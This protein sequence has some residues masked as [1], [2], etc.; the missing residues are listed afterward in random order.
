MYRLNKNHVLKL[1]RVHSLY[2]WSSARRP[3]SRVFSSPSV[4][5]SKKEKAKVGSSQ[6]KSNGGYNPKRRLSPQDNKDLDFEIRYSSIRDRQK[7]SDDAY[8]NLETEI[9]ALYRE[10]QA[11][12]INPQRTVQDYGDLTIIGSFLDVHSG[13]RVILH[14][15]QR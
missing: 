12:M 2:L 5:L 15:A 4:L 13:C 9:R 6:T 14:S 8:H 1:Y 11:I 3:Q 10:R 7:E